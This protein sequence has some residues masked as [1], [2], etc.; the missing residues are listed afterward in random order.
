MLSNKQGPWVRHVALA[1]LAT[2]VLSAGAARAQAPAA[3]IDETEGWRKVGAYVTCAFQVFAAVTPVQ[4]VA[5]VITCG[6]MFADEPAPT[7]G[8]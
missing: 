5:A 2:F 3:P 6:K 4:V 8:A 1:M 7:G